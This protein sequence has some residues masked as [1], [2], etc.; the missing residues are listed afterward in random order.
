MNP[1]P[2]LILVVTVGTQET[3]LLIIQSGENRYVQ[4]KERVQMTVVQGLSRPKGNTK[5][6]YH[7]RICKSIHLGINVD[8]IRF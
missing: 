4:N 1:D 3:G 2:D 6:I 7:T 5:S 8:L